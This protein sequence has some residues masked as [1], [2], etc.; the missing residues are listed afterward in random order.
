MSVSSDPR[1]RAA[2][3]RDRTIDALAG[4]AAAL[5]PP[6]GRKPSWDEW[7][8]VDH[9]TWAKAA[10]C[11]A[12]LAAPVEPFVDSIPNSV[13]RLGL[14]ALRMWL[15]GAAPSA[16]EAARRVVSG[17]VGPGED[18][19]V[20]FGLRTWLDELEPVVSAAAATEVASYALRA[21]RAGVQP[22][23]HVGSPGS[24]RRRWELPGSRVRLDAKVEV[25]SHR[26]PTNP[27]LRMMVLDTTSPTPGRA[28][29]LAAWVALCHTL[30]CR[31]TPAG[32]T[33]KNLRT[34]VGERYD[35]DDDLLLLALT[36]ATEAVEA[37]GESVTEVPGSDSLTYRPGRW[38][39]RCSAL[40]VCAEGR[41]WASAPNPSSV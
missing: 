16:H 21:V 11:P 14:V 32:V 13:R 7:I 27:E 40:D 36:Q 26:A 2:E 8:D 34:G 17:D 9:W 10:E 33:V 24:A 30:V 28:Q 6:E 4:P 41:R 18:D 23:H 12:S 39:H 5:P 3:W 20:G 19:E 29:G 31:V 37:L 38:C 25:A 1:A 35:V 15:R 22:G